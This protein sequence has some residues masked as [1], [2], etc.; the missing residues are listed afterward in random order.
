MLA[1][2]V[3]E[4]MKKGFTAYTSQIF[5]DFENLNTGLDL[6]DF[7]PVRYAVKEEFALGSPAPEFSLKSITGKEVTLSDFRGKMV[8][9]NFW[10]A[11]H[12]E[13]LNKATYTPEIEEGLKNNNIVFVNINVDANE[14][15]WRE[16]VKKS[17]LSGTHLHAAN[18]AD[19]LQQYKLQLSNAPAYYLIDT[20]GT[21]I[22]TK[23]RHPNQNNKKFNLLQALRD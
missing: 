15:L 12:L 6:N 23:A 21:F 16:T 14:K 3:T 5:A 17:K 20:D 2:I 7:L 8:Y 11:Q 10:S 1:S 13:V 18:K 9:L 22:S 19:L 4:A